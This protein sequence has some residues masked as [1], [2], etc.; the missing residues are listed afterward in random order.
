MHAQ[1]WAKRL[2]RMFAA[3]TAEPDRIASSRGCRPPGIAS[4]PMTNW[5]TF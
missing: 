2:A 5:N 4:C 3:L 1:T